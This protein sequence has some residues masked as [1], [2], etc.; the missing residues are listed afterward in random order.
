MDPKDR[1]VQEFDLFL[2]LLN[3]DVQGKITPERELRQGDPLSPY[4][5][6]FCAEGLP[7]QLRIAQLHNQIHDLHFDTDTLFVSHLCF[8]DDTLLFFQAEIG[9][10]NTI[11]DI[12]ANYEKVSGQKINFR[13]QK[14]VLAKE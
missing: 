8:T 9:K 14:C 10:C 7:C 5:F 3:G 12:L 4:L 1:V 13:S 6:P 2:H 11:R